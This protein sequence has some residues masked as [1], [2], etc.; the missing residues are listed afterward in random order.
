MELIGQISDI[1]DIEDDFEN[2]ERVRIRKRYIRDGQNPF[3]FYNNLQFKKRYRFDKDSI[4]YGILPKIEEGLAKINNRGLPISPVIQ[5]LICLRYYATASFQLLLGDI[6]TVSQS[7]TSRIVFRVSLLIAS[8]LKGLHQPNRAR[9]NVAEV[10][11]QK[12]TREEKI[13]RCQQKSSQSTAV[14]DVEGISYGPRIVD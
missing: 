3:E 7:T 1:E 11:A 8:L 13:A 5:L 6:M 9:I 12:A 10:R 2:V 14:I 4:L